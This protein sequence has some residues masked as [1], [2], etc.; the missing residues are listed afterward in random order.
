LYEEPILS[1]HSA[2]LDCGNDEIGFGV[3]Q[4]TNIVI[5]INICRYLNIKTPI[6]KI[7]KYIK[8]K[9]C[10]LIKLIKKLAVMNN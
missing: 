1:V 5:A 7:L 8:N 3:E 6:K 9:K 4:D 2:S 10:L